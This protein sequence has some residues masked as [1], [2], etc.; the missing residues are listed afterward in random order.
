MSLLP[1]RSRAARLL[2]SVLLGAA[3]ALAAG[4]GGD[5]AGEQETLKIA[6]FLNYDTGAEA[7]A[8]RQRGFDLAISHINDGGGVLGRPVAFVV[9]DSTADPA[10]AAAEARRLIEVD[11]VHAIVGPNT[12]ANALRVAEEVTGPARIPMVSPSATSPLLTTAEDGDFFFRTALS[13]VAQGPV[14]ARLVRERGFDNVGVVYR[15]DAWGRGLHETFAAAW[16]GG[17]TS[18]LIEPDAESY[19]PALRE[20]AAH[21]AQA[22][23]V[24]TFAAEAE[25]VLREALDAGL[26]DQFV[27]GD[28]ARRLG[29]VRA[30]GGD[31]L[32]G[33]Y[34][35]AGVGSP[36]TAS[37]AAWEEAYREAHGELPATP[38]VR[39]TYDAVIAIALATEAAG[40]LD[41]AAI[42]D[43]LRAV[44]AP[45]GETVIAGAAGVAR[46][47]EVLAE[48]GDVDYEGASVSM[49]WDANGDL[50]RGHIGI[51]R[52]TKDERI[53]DLE[54][55]AYGE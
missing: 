2:A 34:G 39:N 7:S 41:G 32:G 1:N 24:I 19:L 12:S 10:V 29:L 17:I 15:N 45:P 36:D 14:L 5:D 28:A 6:L 31:R 40:S 35:T 16:D 4:C 51:W 47:L 27:F 18:A 26:Y 25:P 55:V 44:G 37:Q 54:A 52:F 13:D 22:L 21:G 3:L 50:L 20:T 23:V 8:A 30:I 48:G 49:D 33:M 38:Y 11:G 53:E 42:R 46:A 9:A 43:Q